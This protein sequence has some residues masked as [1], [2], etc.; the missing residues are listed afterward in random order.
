[1]KKVVVLF[2]VLFFSSA[3]IIY[4][5]SKKM[6]ES[7]V[8]NWKEVSW[9]YAKSDKKIKAIDNADLKF[10]LANHLV[11][12]KFEQW[13][14][15]PNNQMNFKDSIGNIHHCKWY[16]KGRGNILELVHP[17]KS[18]ETFLVKSTKNNQ[19]ELHVETAVHARGILKITLKRL[20]NE[21]I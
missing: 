13:N 6:D 1:M 17:D 4:S 14:I 16:L 8:G 12:H 7:L 21:K 15:L 20:D 10:E 9:N 11:V 18:K 2:F 5:F 19:L 3:T